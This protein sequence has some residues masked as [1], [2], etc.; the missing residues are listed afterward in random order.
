MAPTEPVCFERPLFTLDERASHGGTRESLPEGAELE[1][2]EFSHSQIPKG[3]LGISARRAGTSGGGARTGDL[4][5]ARKIHRGAERAGV[6]QG[7][8]VD[9]A[10]GGGRGGRSPRRQAN[11]GEPGPAREPGREIRSRKFRRFRLPGMT[12]RRADPRR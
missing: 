8:G 11:R 1:V 6:G 4:E 9:F 10:S 7:A 5:R 2:I 12:P 3:P